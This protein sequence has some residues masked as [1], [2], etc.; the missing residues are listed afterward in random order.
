M[1]ALAD[2][3]AQDKIKYIGLSEVSAAMIRRACKIVHV[4]A[5]QIEYPPWFLD[6]EDPRIGV[7]QACRE[8]SIAT[9][10]YSPIGR[11][12]LSS[13][14]RLL[15]DL[16]EKDSRRMSPQ[17]T[18]ENFSKN[19][20]LVDR[21]VEFAKNKGF[22]ATQLVLGWLMAQGLD[23]IPIPGTTK[24]ERLEENIRALQVGLSEEEVREIRSMVKAADVH[25]NR[26]ADAMLKYAFGDT[27]RSKDTGRM[28]NLFRAKC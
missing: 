8:L 24:I 28:A 9:I 12:M 3:K 16:C 11:G 10:A 6:I 7:L 25:G 26:Y 20:V 22:T 13:A 17:F 4:D 2:L 23:I 1:R 14:I 21:I 27:Q 15:D 18:Q 5:V 19:L